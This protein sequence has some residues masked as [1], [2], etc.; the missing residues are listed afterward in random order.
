MSIPFVVHPVSRPRSRSI[1]TA[2]AGC[3][4]F[5]SRIEMLGYHRTICQCPVYAV[6]ALH[7]E[8]AGARIK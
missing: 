2:I 3:L 4:H 7:S 1:D 5:A 6:F 8:K